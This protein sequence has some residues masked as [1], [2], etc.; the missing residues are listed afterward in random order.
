MIYKI[1]KMKRSELDLAVEWAGKE[2]W[3]PGIDDAECFYQTHPSGFLMGFL[4]SLGAFHWVLY[5]LQVFGGLSLWLAF[6]IFL[7]FS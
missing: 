1:R 3:N 7:I 6:P 4:V 2:G 5:T